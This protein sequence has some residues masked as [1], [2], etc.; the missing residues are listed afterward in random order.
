MDSYLPGLGPMTDPAKS[1]PLTSPTSR[2][3]W[4]PCGRIRRTPPWRAPQVP[5]PS[6]RHTRDDMAFVSDATCRMTSAQALSLTAAQLRSYH[7]AV[8]HFL[9]SDPHYRKGFVGHS[10]LW[11]EVLLVFPGE[12]GL[13]PLPVNDA[14]CRQIVSAGQHLR[15]ES[16]AAPSEWPLSDLPMYLVPRA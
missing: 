9:S 6:A 2:R 10:L 14:V 4:S 5:Q 1:D 11:Q 3:P 13:P 7:L 12:Q 15:L 16:R 8:V